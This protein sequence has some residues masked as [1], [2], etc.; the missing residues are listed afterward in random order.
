MFC[1]FLFYFIRIE[2]IVIGRRDRESLYKKVDSELYVII[3]FKIDY[4]M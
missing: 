4:K 2:V 1:R 3:F